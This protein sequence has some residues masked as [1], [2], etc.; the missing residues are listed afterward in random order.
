LLRGGKDDAFQPHLAGNQARDFDP[1]FA[2]I[3]RFGVTQ[4][5]VQCRSRLELHRDHLIHGE[6]DVLA[7]RIAEDVHGRVAGRDRRINVLG[8]P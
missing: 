5:D 3:R 4:P 1:V 7:V 8:N 2:L 6:S